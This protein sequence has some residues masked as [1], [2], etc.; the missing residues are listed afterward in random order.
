MS[1]DEDTV[2]AEE[3]NDTF[4][5]VVDEATQEVIPPSTGVVHAWGDEPEETWRRDRWATL[6]SWITYLTQMFRDGRFIP[7]VVAA[8]AIAAVS[9]A[10]TLVLRPA[11]ARFSI[12][13]APVEQAPPPP[14]PKPLPPAPKPLPLAPKAAPP[15]QAS[16]PP[17]A[18]PPVQHPHVQAAP[19]PPQSP[20]P[21][22]HPAF[23]RMLRGNTRATQNGA[24]LYLENPAKVDSEA[25][26]M[27]EDLA[28]GGSIQP[29]ITGTLRKSP[30]L[31]PWQAAMVV[32]QAVQAYCPQ[33]A[34]R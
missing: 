27:C 17:V 22:A 7:A 11:P 15:P 32:H 23:T 13:P 5:D 16:P 8:V 9:I 33:Y 29:Y 19:P 2:L 26:A 31:A 21:G 25:E 12:S 1:S 20:P 4:S 6:S 3:S 18:P 10:G 30:S 24:G 14:A 34:T 28:N